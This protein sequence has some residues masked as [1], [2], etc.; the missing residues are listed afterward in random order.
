M[1]ELHS[2]PKYARKCLVERVLNISRVLKY[3]RILNMDK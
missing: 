3:A 1:R 2:V